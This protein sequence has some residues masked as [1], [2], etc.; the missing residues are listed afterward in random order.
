M[1]FYL[2]NING[3]RAKNLK[4]FGKLTNEKLWHK[5]NMQL[6]KLISISIKNYGNNVLKALEKSAVLFKF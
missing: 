4:W 3:L 6:W 1:E 2:A 5:G